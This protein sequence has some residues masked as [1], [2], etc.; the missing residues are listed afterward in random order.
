MN[1][2][3]HKCPAS[4]E[5]GETL[6]RAFERRDNFFIWGNFYEEFERYVKKKRLVSGQ[7]ST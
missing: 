4:G 7:L 5:N 1:I 3:F 6:P 2:C